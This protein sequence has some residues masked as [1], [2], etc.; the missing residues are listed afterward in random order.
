MLLYS[1]LRMIIY[2]MNLV[3]GEKI[4]V[5][6]IKDCGQPLFTLLLECLAF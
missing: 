6:G 2:G 1:G 3:Y 4:E 5:Q